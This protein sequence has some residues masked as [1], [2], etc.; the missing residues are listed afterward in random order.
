MALG[1]PDDFAKRLSS[2]RESQGLS[3]RELAARV[4]AE[5]PEGEGLTGQSVGNYE[6]SNRPPPRADWLAA[7][8]RAFPDLSLPWLIAGE[9][10]AHGGRGRGT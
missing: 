3:R 5:L 1:M 9:G 4:N 6:R 2:W 10:E 8:A 7:L